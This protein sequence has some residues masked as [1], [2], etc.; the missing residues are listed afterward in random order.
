MDRLS[1]FRSVDSPPLSASFDAL[2]HELVENICRFLKLQ[3]LGSL[4]RIDS[5]RY[6][7][8]RPRITDIGLH[9]IDDDLSKSSV[10]DA[11]DRIRGLVNWLGDGEFAGPEDNEI[12]AWNGLLERMLD[13]RIE[14]GQQSGL[15]RHL[16]MSVWR[17]IDGEKLPSEALTDSVLELFVRAEQVSTKAQYDFAS[18][19]DCLQSVAVIEAHVLKLNEF[20]ASIQSIAFPKSLECLMS[21]WAGICVVRL[22]VIHLSTSLP[23]RL[24]AYHRN[25]WELE[26]LHPLLPREIALALIQDVIGIV[27]DFPESVRGAIGA[28][29]E[30][31]IKSL[32][33]NDNE[34]MREHY[35]KAFGRH[36][37]PGQ[38]GPGN[39][40]TLM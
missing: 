16:M 20:N 36:D 33:K 1:I 32:S 2:S 14:P 11:V 12:R 23:D 3:D 7:A 35:S 4:M 10:D 38:N 21:R 25:L 24:R 8:L 9:A 29:T 13:A 30:K 27:I 18:N 31:L 19:F 26:R 34:M 22:K 17:R 6:E 40:C 15:L 28:R 37:I 39:P 5:G